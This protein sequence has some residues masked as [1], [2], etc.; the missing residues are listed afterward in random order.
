MDQ[1]SLDNRLSDALHQAFEETPSV[2]E[3]L[4]TGR[5]RRVG[6][7]YRIDSGEDK[8]HRVTKRLSVRHRSQRLVNVAVDDQT[9]LYG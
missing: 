3:L 7:A 2:F 9:R 1:L 4:R 5:S 8:I 6:L